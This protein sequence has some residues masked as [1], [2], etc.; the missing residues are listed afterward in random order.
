MAK[1]SFLANS[2]Q[3]ALVAGFSSALLVGA[4]A[5]AQD[6]TDNQE[7]DREEVEKIQVT[8]SRIGRIG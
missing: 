7:V 5:Y 2:I 1:K 6:Q 8:G 4:P 3:A